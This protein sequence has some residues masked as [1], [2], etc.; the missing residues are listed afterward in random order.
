MASIEFGC[1]AAK[2]DELVPTSAN[3]FTGTGTVPPARGSCSL[4]VRGQSRRRSRRR[5]RATR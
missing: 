2:I 4:T 5:S 3:T 1:G